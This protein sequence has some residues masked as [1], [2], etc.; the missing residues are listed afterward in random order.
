MDMI[1]IFQY[2]VHWESIFIY[3]IIQYIKD[4]MDLIQTVYNNDDIYEKNDHSRR[5]LLALY[6]SINIQSLFLRYLIFCSEYKINNSLLPFWNSNWI[7]HK[8]ELKLKIK[9]DSWIERGRL[10]S[11]SVRR[12]P[13]SLWTALVWPMQS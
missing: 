6:I 13:N 8:F 2:F 7:V 5:K 9:C 11:L 4:T 12:C 10:L 1:F 3:Y